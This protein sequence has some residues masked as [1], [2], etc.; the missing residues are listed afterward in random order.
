MKRVVAF[1]VVTLCGGFQLWPEPE[2][3]TVREATLCCIQDAFTIDV[4]PNAGSSHMSRLT[5]FAQSASATIAQFAA[6]K[7]PCTATAC[8]AT[9]CFVSV[10]NHGEPFSRDV[11]SEGSSLDFSIADGCIITCSTAYGCMHAIR[12]FLQT[13]DPLTGLAIPRSFKFDDKPQFSHR[14]LLIDTARHFLPV[15]VI[16]GNLQLMSESKLNVLHWHIT[17]HHSFPLQSEVFPGLSSQGAYSPK[18]VYSKAD[19]RRVVSFANSLGIR[20]IPELDMPGH[21][22]SWFKG[23]PELLGIARWAID[24]TRAENYRFLKT[25]LGE[26]K[27][28]F[29]S[30]VFAGPFMMHLGMDEVAGGWDSDGVSAWMKATRVDSKEKLIQYW[31]KRMLRVAA[32]LDMR[33]TMWEDFLVETGDDVSGFNDSDNPVTFQLWTRSMN[34]GVQLSA[35]VKRDVVFSSDFYL[36]K[37]GRTWDTMY[38][39]PLQAGVLG[40]EACMWG[41]RIDATNV[42]Q[43]VW[44]KAAAL[45]ERFWCGSRCALD[46]RTAVVRLAKWRCRMTELF[47]FK[48]APLGIVR[49]IAPDEE[50]TGHTD[51]MQW[52]CREADLVP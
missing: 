4:L 39:T 51:R 10:Q 34:E 17:D 7:N 15:D 12:T 38:E 22:E 6:V 52:Y 42:Y 33:I 35:K 18:A 36:D 46:A 11:T 25:L 19:V 41:E 50:W 32:Q 2:L 21:T 16:L 1:A 28:W 3:V 44:P 23:Y 9:Q 43:R 13:L 49:P 14:G 20:V 5:T 27:E 40:A 8:G 31:V 37:L 47:K 30:D 48:V 45:A 24:P 29:Q 26:V